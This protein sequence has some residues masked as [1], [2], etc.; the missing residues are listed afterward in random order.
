MSVD[1]DIPPSK[2]TLG[3]AHEHWFEMRIAEELE[4][5]RASLQRGDSAEAMKS[6]EIAQRLVDKL[7]N[8]RKENTK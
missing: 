4:L 6:V 8:I 3:G 2:L 1:D 5:A 7:Q